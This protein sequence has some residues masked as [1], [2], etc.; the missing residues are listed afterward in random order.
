MRY[1]QSS[2]RSQWIQRLALGLPLVAAM[3][4]GCGGWTCAAY[5]DAR[6]LDYLVFATMTPDYYLPGSGPILQRKLGLG[7]IPCL[8]IRQQC[9]GFLYGLQVAR[10]P[11]VQRLFLPAFSG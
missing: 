8:D 5:M 3:S 6:Q 1:R 7:T 2:K 11:V 10:H 9:S 4:L